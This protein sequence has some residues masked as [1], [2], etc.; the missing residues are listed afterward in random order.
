MG[1]SRSREDPQSGV[2]KAGLA[3]DGCALVAG[4]NMGRE[5]FG[6]FS[7]TVE[8][9]SGLVVRAL[10]AQRNVQEN[11]KSFWDE[12]LA[13]LPDG[14]PIKVF[15]TPDKNQAQERMEAVTGKVARALRATGTTADVYARKFEGIVAV[16]FI[17]AV[18]VVINGPRDVQLKFNDDIEQLVEGVDRKMLVELVRQGGRGAA[19]AKVQWV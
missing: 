4:P 5:F 12:Q 14:S 8:H 1:Q 19:L 2:E 9:A 18:L 17:P 11:G 7:G 13:E 15:V 6:K 16:D 10:E 3:D